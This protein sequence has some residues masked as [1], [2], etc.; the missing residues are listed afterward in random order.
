MRIMPFSLVMWAPPAPAFVC[1]AMVATPA[2]LLS[3]SSL[4]GR[5]L[6]VKY[7]LIYLSKCRAIFGKAAKLELKQSTAAW[8]PR[9]SG[10]RIHKDSARRAHDGRPLECRSS[11]PG[12][13]TVLL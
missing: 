3:L 11:V 7:K 13:R 1:A 2:V 8:K 6:E 5:A 9:R 12:S 10:I 4:L